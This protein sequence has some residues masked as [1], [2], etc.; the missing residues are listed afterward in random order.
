MGDFYFANLI[1]ITITGNPIKSGFLGLPEK[2][3]FFFPVGVMTFFKEFRLAGYQP[4]K[5]MYRNFIGPILFLFV[6]YQAS[7]QTA[8]NTISKKASFFQDTELI[9]SDI[10]KAHL[11]AQNL[12]TL[13]S[14][15]YYLNK[16]YSLSKK[17]NY[18]KG[19]IEF[20]RLKAVS[21]FIQ[22]KEDSLS[23]FIEKAF[24][25][26]K[27]SGNLKEQALV[28]D[29]RAFIFQ[30]RE[31]NDSATHYYIEA[32]KIADKLNDTKFSAEISNNLSTI[33]WSIG[34]YNKAFE[35]AAN[36]YQNGLKLKDTLLI[37]N[38]L[39][40]LGNAKTSLK[41]YDTGMV[42]YNRVNE[43]T[44][45]PVKYNYVL[46]RAL[47]NE[48]S[49][50]TDRNKLDESIR[51]YK[52]IIK[53]SS[54]VAPSLLSYI[55]SGLGAAEL[56]ENMFNDAEMHLTKAIKMGEDAGEKTGLRD[57]YL[58][59]SNVKKAQAD[60]KSALFYREKYEQLNDTLTSKA[61]NKDIHQLEAKYN[62]V[63]KDSKIAQQQLAIART[64]NIIQ[65][66]NAVN[67]AL[68]A[69]L[70]FLLILGFLIYRNIL[71]RQKLLRKN[72]E[73]KKE[74]IRELEK[75]RKLIAVQSVLKGEEEERNRLARDL[76]DGV[77]GLLWGI[78]LSMST[79]KGN[80]FLPEES[81]RSFSNVIAQLDQ[82]IAEL[83]RV[84]HN[85][86]PEALI[87]FGLKEALE[88]YCE[89]VNHSKQIQVRVQTYGMETRME[90][91]VEIVIYR[92]I[93]E[94]LT[95]V[96]KHAEAEKVLIQLVCGDDKFNLTVE[97]DGKGFDTKETSVGAGLA[98]IKARAA[99]LNG[100]VDIVSQK[101]EG[102]SVH[103]EGSSVSS[104]L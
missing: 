72:E 57:S 60:F 5:K 15:D 87:K 65:R 66:K 56:K 13:D 40:N 90:Q 24:N 70:A 93:Q 78:K 81:A 8:V 2:G 1:C 19:I 84:S 55:Y 49:I 18:D 52:E 27:G 36:A 34:D 45:D 104:G 17:I 31:E 42:L 75:E 58:L 61:V 47:A 79:M 35:Y 43:F 103:V 88:N 96:I 16:F 73:L 54:S 77:G 53:L 68:I 37:T 33:F 89:S 51:K 63:K 94:L 28:T 48:A 26:A 101:G 85:M 97:D 4:S 10:K 46:F 82:S 59:M 21:Y 14:A 22:Q 30:S 98:N 39:F 25:L 6:F 41:Q 69:A 71:N 92:I 64:K 62:T 50:L 100:S 80:V 44:T 11:Y 23:Q 3:Y 83:R 102:T 99:Y 38:G 9:N 12:A 86:M 74:K 91:S 32:L 29:L 20:F 76:H 7:S 67:V 95:N